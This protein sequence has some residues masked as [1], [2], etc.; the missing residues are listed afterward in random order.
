MEPWNV[1]NVTDTRTSERLRKAHGLK[2]VLK[3]PHSKRWRACRVSSNFAKR[4]DC[5]VFT[6]AFPVSWP[7]SLWV[8]QLGCTCSLNFLKNSSIIFLAVASM[9]REPM[10][11]INPPTCASASQCSSV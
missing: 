8:N 1:L 7:W 3:P 9:R 11:A 6:A 10:A 4:L 5:G 2:A